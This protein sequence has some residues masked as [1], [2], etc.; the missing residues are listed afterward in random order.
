MNALLPASLLVC[1]SADLLLPASTSRTTCLTRSRSPQPAKRWSAAETRSKCDASSTTASS[2]L[3]LS[4][5]SLLKP[6]ASRP[7]FHVACFML[8]VACFV[9]CRMVHVACYVSYPISRHSTHLT[10]HISCLTSPTVPFLALFALW[11]TTH[12]G[13]DSCGRHRPG[14]LGH[15]TSTPLL[16]VRLK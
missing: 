10:S 5:L 2:R 1:F 15:S 4:I 14:D 16:H 9:S 12:A 13:A 8:H 11:V 3:V 7:M 6:Q